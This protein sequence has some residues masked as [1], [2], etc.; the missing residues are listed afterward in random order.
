M[1]FARRAALLLR[2]PDAHHSLLNFL[3]L[4]IPPGQNSLQGYAI[5]SYILAR[6]THAGLHV[7]DP[8]DFAVDRIEPVTGFPI[9][10]QDNREV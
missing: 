3:C 5:G 7:I 9:T 4:R 10:D 8:G 2:S 1:P 6:E